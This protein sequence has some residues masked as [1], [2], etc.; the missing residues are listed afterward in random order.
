MTIITWNCNMAFRK[1]ANVILPYQPDILVVQECEHP[2]KINFTE[3]L[4]QPT[5]IIWT[6]DNTN[7]G[8][9]IFLY[10]GFTGHMH[11]AHNTAFKF[12]APTVI[13]KGSSSFMLFGVWANNPNDKDG[14]YVTQIWKALAAYK[15]IIKKNSTIITGDFNSNAIWDKPRREGNHSTIVQLL[16]KKT[17]GS[18]YHSYYN[19]QQGKEAHATWYLHRN[20]IKPYHLD[21]CFTSANMLQHLQHVE[22]GNA[23]YWLQYSDHMPVISTFNI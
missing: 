3:H 11:K 9:G 8:L 17:I 22:I 13:K 19:Q 1:K 12:I 15:N 23:A 16:A 5:G 4:Q 14:A 6:G 7:K 20:A 18:T 10:N 2:D 21:Y